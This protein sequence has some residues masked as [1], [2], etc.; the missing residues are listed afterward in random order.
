MIG[1]TKHADESGVN[2]QEGPAW[3]AAREFGF[4]MSLVEVAL[5]NTPEQRL[6]EH[7]R[8]LD[9]ILEIQSMLPQENANGAK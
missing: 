7:Q 9:L 2:A 8:F 3:K 5:G 1:M 4:D 6:D